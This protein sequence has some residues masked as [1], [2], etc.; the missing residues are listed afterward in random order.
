MS[1]D[2]SSKKSRWSLVGLA[3]LTVVGLLAVLPLAAEI[4]TGCDGQGRKVWYSID[5]EGNLT[6]YVRTHNPHPSC[7]E[8]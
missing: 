6:V 1:L 5:D 4:L 8:G 3:V 2:V 7:A